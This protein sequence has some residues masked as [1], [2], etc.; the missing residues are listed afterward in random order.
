MFKLHTS[1][2]DEEDE[3]RDFDTKGGAIVYA[4]HWFIKGYCGNKTMPEHPNESTL[5]DLKHLIETLEAGN[6]FYCSK[7]YETTRIE[8]TP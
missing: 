4:A 6:Q 3:V 7:F 1:A 2:L 5:E 8:P